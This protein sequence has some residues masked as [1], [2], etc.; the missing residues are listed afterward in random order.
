[1]PT[2]IIDTPK[3]VEGLSFYIA[4][5]GS[6]ASKLP[7]IKFL[8][9]ESELRCLE[10]DE[11]YGRLPHASKEDYWELHAKILAK[12]PNYKIEAITK[13]NWMRENRKYESVCQHGIRRFVDSV[14]LAFPNIIIIFNNL[15]FGN[16]EEWN[17][18]KDSLHLEGDVNHECGC[19]K[20]EKLKQSF[21]IKTAEED[22]KLA[23]RE[24]E[25]VIKKA[26]T[27]A[28]TKTPTV[29]HTKG[30]TK[31]YSADTKWITLK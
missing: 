31:T 27:K 2:L 14:Y 20:L 25:E 11:R 26:P 17:L 28:P 29:A 22:A 10:T 5:I 4:Y 9:E 30:H 13:S 7:Q 8:A 19:N 15:R 24:K 6:Q 18:S 3:I 16:R 23:A 12:N 1:M 21:I